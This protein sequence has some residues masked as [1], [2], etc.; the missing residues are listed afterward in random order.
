MS[1][2]GIPWYTYTYWR[3]YKHPISGS[4]SSKKI[5]DAL[6]STFNPR[7]KTFAWYV[8]AS[9]L[10]AIAIVA[11]FLKIINEFSILLS[12]VLVYLI[13][14]EFAMISTAFEERI[15]RKKEKQKKEGYHKQ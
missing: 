3:H 11:L 9:V 12:F 5:S 4:H 2:S 6:S 13:V 7:K 1:K 15:K 10:V 8:F 14:G